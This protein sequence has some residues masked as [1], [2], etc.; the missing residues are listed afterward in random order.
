MLSLLDRLSKKRQAPDM[1]ESTEQTL[2]AAGARERTH[3]WD[4]P[5]ATL[6]ALPVMAGLD[7]LEAMGSGALPLP[8]V[9]STL[10]IRPVEAERGRV[11][12]A[13][14]PAEY[15]VNPLGTVH[16]GVLA[17]LLDTCAACAVHT[18]LP[19]GTGYTSIDLSVRFL[20]PVTAASGPLRGEGTVL[21]SGRR[22]ALAEARVF[23]DKGRL[24]AHAT[25]T[26]LIL[27]LGGA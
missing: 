19:A 9:M 26:C 14:D 13:L 16:G 4:D 15:H 17:T 7:L 12:F 23:D 21:S 27:E 24:L 10:G 8:P 1:P 6:E 3:S 25:S 2:S 11:V 18:T 20:R 5:A 22:T